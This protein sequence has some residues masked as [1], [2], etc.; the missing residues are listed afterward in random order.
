MINKRL[1]QKQK[2]DK[3]VFTILVRHNENLR[4]ISYKIKSWF[5]D[6]SI[7]KPNDG[8]SSLDKIYI[9]SGI[10]TKPSQL[11]EV[12]EMLYARRF[13]ADKIKSVQLVSKFIDS[14]LYLSF[15]IQYNCTL[16]GLTLNDPTH[17]RVFCDSRNMVRRFLARGYNDH[18]F[19][20]ET[21][22]TADKL[23]KIEMD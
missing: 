21:T 19:Y 14:Q 22:G 18:I 9:F 6:P 4:L 11:D 8:Q 23:I 3:I 13:S 12:K 5:N 7:E 10:L 20:A 16:L 15:L 2:E 17:V 1:F